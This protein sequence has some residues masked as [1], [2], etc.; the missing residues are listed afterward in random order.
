[1]DLN[2]QMEFPPAPTKQNFDDLEAHLKI[3]LKELGSS[4]AT[5]CQKE[6]SASANSVADPDLSEQDLKEFYT[7]PFLIEIAFE[8][9][10]RQRIHLV[11]N[12]DLGQQDQL[13]IR[14]PIRDGYMYE[15]KNIVSAEAQL[16]KHNK[17]S[18]LTDLDLAMQ[19]LSTVKRNGET[20]RK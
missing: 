3:L 11:T 13:R 7:Q 17:P 2:Y 14:D 10:N 6:Q 12:I 1:M 15:Q 19:N 8:L 4:L 16:V 5:A 9:G 18:I 20:T